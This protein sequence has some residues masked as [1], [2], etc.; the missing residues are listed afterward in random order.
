MWGHYLE[1]GLGKTCVVYADLMTWLMRDVVEA[2]VVV[3]PGYLRG[4]WINEAA[5]CGI[6]I[7]IVSWP[8][9]A[10]GK[11]PFIFLINYEAL[12]HSGGEYLENVLNNY[13]CMLVLDEPS[14]LRTH[15]NATTKKIMHLAQYAAVRRICYGTPDPEDALDLYSQLRF[16]GEIPGWNPYAFR[17]RYCVM[18]GYMGKQVKGRKNEE[19]LAGILNRCS[20]RALKEQW[21]K[22]APEKIL[23][24]R[25][26]EMQG[27]QLEHYRSMYADFFTLLEHHGDE[28]EVYADMVITQMQKLQQIAR[29]FMLVD[30]KPHD[31][32][33]GAKNPALRAMEGILSETRGKTIVFAYHRHAMD[34]LEQTLQPWRPVVMRGGMAPVAVDA[35]KKVFNEDPNCRVIIAQQTV[36]ARGHD[37]LGQKG[38][39]RCSTTVFYENTYS[40]EMRQQAEDRNHRYGQDT[41]VVYID[42]IASPADRHAVKLLR[43]KRKSGLE[44][45]R[46]LARGL[47]EALT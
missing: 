24:E 36:G 39:D 21:W 18:G 15:S 11:A 10:G 22:D 19:E 7:P 29:G 45:A 4:T 3:L 13:R 6:D 20:F 26:I 28:I 37:L 5:A 17:N 42:L 44:F 35:L 27:K 1:Q 30:G 41:N 16:L 38:K 9:R 32:M 34:Q 23:T 2:M 47:V 12:L 31:I 14:V 46:V 25:T 8:D 33:P 43:E 40:N